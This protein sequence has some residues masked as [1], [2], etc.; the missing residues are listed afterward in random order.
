MDYRGF[1]LAGWMVA[2]AGPVVE[3]AQTAVEWRGVKVSDPSAARALRHALEDASRRLLTSECQSVIDGF[4]DTAGQPLRMRLATFGVEVR[5][6]LGWIQFLDGSTRPC[7]NGSTLF[8][9]APGSRVVR[10]CLVALERAGWQGADHL[11]VTVIHEMLHTLGLGENPP[12]SEEITGR[13]RQ[14]CRP[15]PSGR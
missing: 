3:A 13:V 2:M 5:E 8:Y 4:H 14:K 10:A 7:S 12:S 15:H 6:Y 11:A 9:T 1:L